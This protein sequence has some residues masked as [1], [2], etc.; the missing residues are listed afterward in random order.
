MGKRGSKGQGGREPETGQCGGERG[1]HEGPRWESA[2]ETWAPGSWRSRLTRKRIRLGI[3]SPYETRTQTNISNGRLKP[4]RDA[5]SKTRDLSRGHIVLCIRSR[6]SE[7][8]A[9]AARRGLETRNDSE[10][11]HGVQDVVSRLGSCGA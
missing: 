6:D 1:F 8:Q 3:G 5:V 4:V 9:K 2:C 11:R 10:A 7:E